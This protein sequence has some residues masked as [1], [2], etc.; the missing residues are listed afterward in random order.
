M[1]E[2]AYVVILGRNEQKKDLPWSMRLK[3]K[4][5]STYSLVSNVLD[6]ALLEQTSKRY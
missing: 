3:R 2:G 4:G 5:A 6:K 1:R